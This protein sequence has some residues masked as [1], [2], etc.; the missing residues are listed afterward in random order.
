[1]EAPNNKAQ[2]GRNTPIAQKKSLVV[3]YNKQVNKAK[4]GSVT[5]E[6]V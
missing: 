5:P 6:N 4:I 1:M 2:L 3:P